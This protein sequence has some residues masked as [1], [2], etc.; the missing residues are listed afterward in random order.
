VR[1]ERQPEPSDLPQDDAPHL[2]VVDDDSRIRSL[3]T[4]FL[5]SNGFRVTAA[6][7]AEE[8]RRQLASL[9]FDLLVVDVMMPGENGLEFTEA[10]R[11]KSSVPILMLTAR[12][13]TP[14]RIRGLEIGA[15]DYLAKPFEPR[16]LLLR[17]TNIL[18]RGAP[19]PPPVTETLRFGPFTFH[20]ERGELK[21]DSAV[22]RITDR[23]R[24][25]LRIFAERPGQTVGRQDFL[26]ISNG[27]GERAVD[28]Q[29]NRL[30]RKLEPDPSNPVYL[31]TSRGVGYRL[32]VD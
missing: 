27:G 30:R 19:P 18:K 25:I 15:D 21:R 5:G 11:Q 1:P 26:K 31:Q 22:V 29:M 6:E 4:R 14:N 8:A 23:E 2:L 24:E 9:A 7:S 17:I 20:K 28:V 3:L 13:E 16:E 12:S 10:L 32:L